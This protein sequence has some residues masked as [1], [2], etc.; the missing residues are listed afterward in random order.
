MK[1]IKSIIKST[2]ISTSIAA[3]QYATYT[4]I[5]TLCDV[6]SK[7]IGETTKIG[8]FTTTYPK[9]ISFIGTMLIGSVVLDYA[10]HNHE[11]IVKA[12]GYS[13]DASSTA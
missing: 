2:V 8:S 6:V 9:A 3:S 10:L 4:G 13:D 7:V 1:I 11:Y 12:L 5:Q